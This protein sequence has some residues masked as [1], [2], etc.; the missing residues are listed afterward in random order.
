MWV[1]AGAAV[2]AVCLCAALGLFVFWGRDASSTLAVQVSPTFGTHGGVTAN[3]TPTPAPAT[4][5]PAS[6]PPPSDAWRSPDPN[7]MI[8]VT[9]GSP[10]TLDPAHDYETNGLTVVQNIY[11]TLIFFDRDNADRFIPQLALEVPSPENGGISPDGLTYTFK[12]RPDVHFHNGALLTAEDVAFT[13][14][15][16]LLQGGINSPQWLLAEPLLGIGV[17]DVSSL[18]GAQYEANRDELKK[19]PAAALQQVCQQV[20]RAITFDAGQGTVTFHLKQRWGP[21]LGTLANAWG[22]IQSKGWLIDNGAWNGD[23]TTWQNFYGPTSGELNKTGLGKQANGTGPYQLEYWNDQEVALVANSNYWRREAA[24]PDGP[25]GAPR[26][27]KIIIRFIP[28]FSERLETLKK[29]EADFMRLGS[30]PDIGALDAL[31]GLDCARYDTDCAPTANPDG[32]LMRVRGFALG[33]RN[34]DLFFNF[35]INTESSVLGSGK[36]DGNGIPSNF[37]ANAHVRRGFASCFDYDRFLKEVMGGEGLRAITVMPPNML[38]YNAATPYY[39]YNSKRCEDELRQAIFDGKNVWD[40]GFTLS[41][42]AEEPNRGSMMIATIWQDELNAINPKFN[43][44]VQALPSDDFDKLSRDGSLPYYIL[45]WVEDIHDPHNW[46]YPYVVGN[47]GSNQQ[48]PPEFLA[49]F[50]DLLRASVESNDPAMR[51]DVYQK[52]N[53]LY[54]EQ[55]PSIPMFQGIG[56]QYLQRW[57]SGFYGNPVLPGPYFYAFSKR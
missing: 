6:P 29:G 56:R 22:S 27:Q 21:F 50:R 34:N 24:W 4:P 47:L 10:S 19:A 32:R 51:N 33:E 7:T 35:S 5:P 17:Y 45:G 38:G 16:N 49:P 55:A 48:M 8:Y 18:V 53:Q 23:C 39:T 37:F 41:L 54:Y 28:G 43:V 14:Q 20:T 2:L 31:T 40:T 1:G 57:V 13:F 11:D 46:A 3:D 25:S 52:F 42:P 26:I 12:I 15:R 44:S 36:L 30:S 9:G